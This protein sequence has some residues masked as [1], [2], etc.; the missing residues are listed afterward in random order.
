MHIFIT[1]GAGFIGSNFVRFWTKHHP[2]DKITVF[3]KLTYAGNLSSL[4][5]V[6]EKISFIEGDI[7]NPEQVRSALTGVDCIVHFA[8]E[9]HVD[10][11]IH[12]PYIFTQTNVLGTHILLESARQLNIARFHHIS[13]DEVFGEIPLEATWKFNE[14]TS[15]NPNSPYA[16]SKAGSDH[17]VRAYHKT[18]GLPVTISN[19]SNNFGPYHYPEKFIPRSIIR[20][21][22]GENIR[23]YSPGNQI[24]DWLYVEDHCRAIELILSK[25]KIGETYCIGGLHNGIS[26]IEVAKTLLQIMGLPESRIEMVTDRPG[27]DQK[28]DIDWS[29]IHRELGWSP[30]ENFPELLKQTV[31]WFKDNE[32][33]WQPLAEES[34]SFYQTKGEQLIHSHV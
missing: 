10:R 9:S 19:C 7:T 20:L 33:W 21:L 24:R 29:K 5:E 3:D 6:V 14:Q 1:G 31:D 32:T 15:Y 18:Y 27:H 22:K 25:G 17:L 12:N 30:T 26:N 11:S 2:E 16:A 28:Y 13:T 8:A 4:Q 23:L 34:E